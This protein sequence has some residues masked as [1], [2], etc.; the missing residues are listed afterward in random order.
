M[1]DSLASVLVLGLGNDILTDDAV[2]LHVVRI[3]RELLGGE[4][5]IEVKATTE[6]GLALLDEIAGREGVVLVDAVQTG[7]A[8]PGHIHELR[9]DEL[10]KVFRTS[11][12]FLGV[13]ETLALGKML[14]LQMP[15]HVRIFAI[16]V[17]DPFTLGTA[18]TPAVEHA[19]AA[20][21]E[22]VAA[23]AREIASELRRTATALA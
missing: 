13:G 4:P 23:Q 7:E 22:R 15:G 18:M 20:A 12:H 6:M 8:P 1:P 5:D 14:G 21:A 3:V 10:G 2:G 19:A 9:P 17:K 16:E 11:P